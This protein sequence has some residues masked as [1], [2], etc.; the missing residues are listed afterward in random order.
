[1]SDSGTVQPSHVEC[2]ACRGTGR[3]FL[4]EAFGDR[5]SICGTCLGR[6]RV[7]PTKREEWLDA[8]LVTRGEVKKMIAEAL[9]A[10][11]RKGET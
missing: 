4:S 8:Q 3:L 5:G 6:E 9:L 7:T 2:P 10:G 11:R 1:M